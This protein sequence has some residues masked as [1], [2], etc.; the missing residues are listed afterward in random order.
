MQCVFSMIIFVTCHNIEY[1]FTPWQDCYQ[2]LHIQISTFTRWSTNVQPALLLGQCQILPIQENVKSGSTGW[3][4]SVHGTSHSLVFGLN[5]TN[6]YINHL[7]NS[8]ELSRIELKVDQYVSSD[9][10]DKQNSY[11]WNSGYPLF[12]NPRLN[13]QFKCLLFPFQSSTYLYS[14]HKLRVVGVN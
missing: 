9:M 8:V 1:T 3:S 11:V 2:V 14:Y 12:L 6:D 10:L 13:L 4:N 7:T 5:R